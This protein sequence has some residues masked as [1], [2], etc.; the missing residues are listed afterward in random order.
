MLKRDLKPGEELHVGDAVI[1]V[2][3]KHGQIVSLAI[4]APREV[5]IE[6]KGSDGEANT[7]KVSV[8]A[9]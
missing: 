8:S 4:Q 9:S 6:V 1:K 3:K 5:K 2:V 7:R